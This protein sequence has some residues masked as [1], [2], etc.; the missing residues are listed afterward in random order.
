MRYRQLDSSGDYVFGG[1]A[2]DFFVNSPEAVAQAVKTR[3]GLMEGEWFLDTT[4]GTPYFTKVLGAGVMQ[5]YDQ[6]IQEVILNTQ[7]VQTLDEY[8]SDVDLSTR[9]ATIVCLITTIYGKIQF[10]VSL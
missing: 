4:V 5:Q 9:A 6:A 3:L 10:T 7:G 2:A 1:N 8:A